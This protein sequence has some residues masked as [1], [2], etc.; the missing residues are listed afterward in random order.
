M[1]ANTRNKGK[2]K[3]MLSKTKHKPPAKARTTSSKS[4]TICHSNR[5]RS[6]ATIGQKAQ[7]VKIKEKKGKPVDFSNAQSVSKFITGSTDLFNNE[8]ATNHI[9]QLNSNSALYVASAHNS[10]SR[11]FS[12][13]LNHPLLSGLAEMESDPL[14][15]SEEFNLILLT[16]GTKTQAK[17]N[18][19]NTCLLAVA[20]EL[21]LKDK[22][23]VNL[24]TR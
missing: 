6:S 15:S 11:V 24:T 22:A 4:K 17:Y 19:L 1:P 23:D 9:R 18:I 10:V 12:I 7:P 20:L 8:T 5:G 16:R 21:K 13:L 3:Q 2:S 14:S